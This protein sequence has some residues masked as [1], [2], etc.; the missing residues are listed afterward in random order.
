MEVAGSD[1]TRSP[2]GGPSR[3]AEAPTVPLVDA[4]CEYYTTLLIDW[5]IDSSA[6]PSHVNGIVKFNENQPSKFESS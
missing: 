4:I 2:R 6:T 3:P 1:T 5:L